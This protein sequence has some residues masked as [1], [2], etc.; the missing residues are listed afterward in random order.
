MNLERQFVE[1]YIFDK[2]YGGAFLSV[3]GQGNVLN[4]TKDLIFQ[5]N[6]ILLLA[7]MN[8]QS[9]DPQVKSY[10]DSA[11]GWIVNHLAWG[12]GGAGTWYCCSD[13]SG[14]VAQPQTWLAQSESY[15]SL[16]LLW[17]YRITGNTTYLQYARTNLNYQMSNFPDGHIKQNL[18]PGAGDITYR[19]PE[20]MSFYS[21]YQLSGDKSYLDYAEKVQNAAY[22]VNGWQPDTTLPNGTL[23]KGGPNGNSIVDEVLFALVSGDQ[24]AFSEGQR[25]FAAYETYGAG[26]RDDL[27]NFIVMD[28][29]FWTM[30]HNEAFRDD[31]LHVYNEL[32]QLWDS[33]PPYGFWADGRR[34]TKTCFM[35]GY[36]LLDMTSPVITADPS[37]QLVTATITDPPFNWLDMTFDGIGVNPASVY[38]FYSVDGNQWSSG[39]VMNQTGTDTFVA[40]VPQDIASQNPQYLISAS[41]YF[42]NTSTYQFTKT[43]VSQ[44]TTIAPPPPVIV[45]QTTATHLTANRHAAPPNGVDPPP[46]TPTAVGFTVLALGIGGMGFSVIAVALYVMR[47]TPQVAEAIV[48]ATEHRYRCPHCVECAREHFQ[49]PTCVALRKIDACCSC[50][51]MPPGYCS[52][53]SNSAQV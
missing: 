38:L 36:P 33:S 14:S 39:M 41:D 16:G 34:L 25:L 5:T 4:S 52:H 21:M 7:G 6:V 50:Y 44:T 47:P 8:A 51:V 30:T 18:A 10:V 2:T 53:C 20:R 1:N 22:G 29:A 45:T 42:N 32:L 13:R 27:Q 48:V 17:A 24:T 43:F 23:V 3:D 46:V 49:C 40:T 11:A 19:S 9:P 37:G 28:F 35:R 15:V 31:A 26:S 12:D